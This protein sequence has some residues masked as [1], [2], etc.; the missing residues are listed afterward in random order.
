MRAAGIDMGKFKLERL[1]ERLLGSPLG[2][3]IIS[4]LRHL[5]PA[6]RVFVVNY[7]ATYERDEQNFRDHLDFYQSKFDLL[8]LREVAPRLDH[9]KKY[10]RPGLL[11][12]F[13]DGAGSNY[14]V[15]AR[16]LE[17]R[18]ARGVFMIPASFV[19]DQ[20]APDRGLEKARAVQYGMSYIDAQAELDADGRISMTVD[21][22]VD[23]AERG[24]TIGVHGNNHLRLGDMR[25]DEELR[26]EVVDAKRLL[27]ASLGQE[28]GVFCWIGGETSSYSRRA[29]NL[30]RSTGY[31][32]GFMTCCA[33]ISRRTDP[34]QWHR[35][36][37][38]SG[39]SVARARLVLGGLYEARYW[40]KRR[41]VDRLTAG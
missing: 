36:N 19:E 30:I 41:F 17:E 33:P 18:S 3:A 10:D 28:L 35:F 15:A 9:A 25:T 38:E 32:I 13:D 26:K 2:F 37:I 40:R 7:H 23:L 20:T 5:A 6:N 29:S 4:K 27:G 31:N 22:V 14:R 21:Q 16:L 11:L 8:S 39:E 12:T 34:L 1:P 24:H